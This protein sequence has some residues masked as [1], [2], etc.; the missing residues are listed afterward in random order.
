MPF[1]TLLISLLVI[2]LSCNHN[3]PTPAPREAAGITENPYPNIGAIPLPEGFERTASTPNSF[4]AYLRNIGLKKDKTVYLYNGRKKQYQHAQF[5]VL[6]ITVGDR[7]L[8]QCADAVMRL[9]A[10]YLYT[11]KKYDSLIFFDNDKRPYRFQ[12]PYTRERFSSYLDQVFGMCGSASLSRQLKPAAERDHIQPGDVL[13][14]GGFPG[15]AA[16]VVDVAANKQGDKIYLLAQGYMP[17]QDIHIL[18]NPANRNLS[19]WYALT[20]A[21]SITTPEYIF[22]RHEF[23]S[24]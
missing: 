8:Q 2:G 21:N 17:S 7:D 15:H 18:R 19:P 3:N 9:R 11:Q 10:E 12:P 14:R 24:W 16:L 22:Y 13:I 1:K 5:A 23:R 6:N 20:Q 4:A